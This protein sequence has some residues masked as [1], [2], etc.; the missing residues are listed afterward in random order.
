MMTMSPAWIEK[1]RRLTLT[2]CELPLSRLPVGGAFRWIARCQTW[3][4]ASTTTV[5]GCSQ[6]FLAWGRT[7]SVHGLHFLHALS[8][9]TVLPG[10]P[11]VFTLHL[12]DLAYRRRQ[13]FR[14]GSWVWKKR[15]YSPSP[16][17]SSP[18]HSL[19]PLTLLPKP[20]QSN[21]YEKQSKTRNMKEWKMEVSKKKENMKILKMFLSW[22]S[23]GMEGGLTLAW[24]YLPPPTSQN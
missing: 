9:R 7:H 2:N 3:K 6:W 1:P 4:T 20:Q 13:R 16:S 17:P 8:E 18:L 22:F 23:W 10:G 12:V 21:I 5:Q 19:S 14:G 24:W 15:K 11:R